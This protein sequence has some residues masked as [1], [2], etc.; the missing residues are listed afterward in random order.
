[1]RKLEAECLIA[2][3]YGTESN[4]CDKKK[5]NLKQLTNFLDKD[6]KIHFFIKHEKWEYE[7]KQYRKMIGWVLYS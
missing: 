2:F 4:M 5:E 1:M 7:E 3:N 6:Q